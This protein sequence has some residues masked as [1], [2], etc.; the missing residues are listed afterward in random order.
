MAGEERVILMVE[1]LSPS[2][3]DEMERSDAIQTEVQ[4]VLTRVC[5]VLLQVRDRQLGYAPHMKEAPLN[6]QSLSVLQTVKMEACRQGQGRS[7]GG[8]FR[9]SL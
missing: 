9:T 2:R 4:G 7:V 8:Q 3:A 5:V 1:P 6:A